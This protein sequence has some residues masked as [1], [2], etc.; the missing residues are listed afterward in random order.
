MMLYGLPIRMPGWHV[1]AFAL[2]L[3]VARHASAIANGCPIEHSLLSKMKAALEARPSVPIS[4]IGGAIPFEWSAPDGERL[5][6][7][8]IQCCGVKPDNAAGFLLIAQGNAMSATETA[9][10]FAPLASA[11]RLDVFVVDYRGIGLSG[12]ATSSSVRSIISDYRGLLSHLTARGYG[13]RV[14]YAIS[15][16]GVVMLNATSQR[17]YD[18]LVLDAVPSRTGSSIS[19][20]VARVF[21]CR[22]NYDAIA[23]LPDDMQKVVLLHGSR[24]EQVTAGMAKE[25]R[26]KATSRRAR[27]F[28]IPDLGHPAADTASD[29]RQRVPLVSSIIN[30]R[31]Q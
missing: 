6:G 23:H 27:S 11:A 21:G 28:V 18:L 20:F 29:R 4:Q 22:E 5:H 25:L 30:G 7:V 1:A 8:Q 31:A 13:K 19:K 14:V 24:D 16:G 17:D 10:T 2:S 9:A 26:G 15:F 12:N 3:G